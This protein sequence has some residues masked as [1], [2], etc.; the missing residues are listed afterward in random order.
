MSSTYHEGINVRL[1]S[2]LTFALDREEWLGSRSGH[3]S[4][5]KAQRV[6]TEQIGRWAPN[7][8]YLCQQSN[9]DS[10]V[11]Q[12]VLKKAINNH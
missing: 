12:S 4:A 11:E 3:F 5:M 7:V 6:F 10:S 9:H 8:S 2:L 1:R